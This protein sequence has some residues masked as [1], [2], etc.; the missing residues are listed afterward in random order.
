VAGQVAPGVCSKNLNKRVEFIR[1]GGK[2]RLW[3]QARHCKP[4]ALPE[5]FS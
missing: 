1:L 2:A 3:E 5:N 4:F